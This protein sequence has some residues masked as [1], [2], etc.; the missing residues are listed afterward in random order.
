ML[1][2]VQPEGDFVRIINK[3]YPTLKL[4]KKGKYA[5]EVTISDG[6]NTNDQLWKL[7]PRFK[8]EI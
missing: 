5:D 7:K 8:T 2:K 6:P 4:G 1:F 3:N